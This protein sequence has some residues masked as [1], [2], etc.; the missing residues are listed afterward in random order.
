MN[1]HE[2]RSV[3]FVGGLIKHLRGY[4]QSAEVV[5]IGTNSKWNRWSISND[6]LWITFFDDPTNAS[7]TVKDMIGELEQLDENMPVFA[8]G[9]KDLSIWHRFSIKLRGT[10]VVFKEVE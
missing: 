9:S 10:K 3:G 7:V 1:A 6:G 2:R 8:W 5:F 4:D